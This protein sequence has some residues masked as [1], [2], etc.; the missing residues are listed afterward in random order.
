MINLGDGFELVWHGHEPVTQAQPLGGGERQYPKAL[1]TDPAP[2]SLPHALLQY[3]VVPGHAHAHQRGWSPGPSVR[4]G[5]TL[6]GIPGNLFDNQFHRLVA[7]TGRGIVAVPDANESMA[8]LLQ[9]RLGALLARAKGDAGFHFAS[10]QP[11]LLTVEQDRVIPVAHGDRILPPVAHAMSLSGEPGLRSMELPGA[12]G[13]QGNATVRRSWP[14]CRV[15]LSGAIYRP[16]DFS[17]RTGTSDLSR[18]AAASIRRSYGR[19]G[20]GCGTTWL[21]L[22]SV[23]RLVSTPAARL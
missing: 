7:H 8:V 13:R 10:R 12:P 19:P 21:P 17:R 1:R 15:R 11:D 2:A 6:S 14:R 3:P 4:H 16:R 9:Q 20:S 5:E 18:D 22:P 23:H